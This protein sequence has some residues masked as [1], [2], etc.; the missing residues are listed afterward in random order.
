MVQINLGAGQEQRCRCREQ[1][2]GPGLQGRGGMNWETGI[3]VCALPCVRQELSSVLCGDQDGW[4]VG[5]MGGRKK[6]SIYIHI[7]NS[8]CST[9]L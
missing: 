3:D 7:A 6:D 5:R 2:C 8:L 9:T 4:N 1:M